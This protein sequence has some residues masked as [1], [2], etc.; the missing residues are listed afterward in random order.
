MISTAL[1]IARNT[2]ME[3][4]RQPVVL[5]LILIN[6]VLNVL[7]TWSTGFS[8]GYRSELGEV[9]GDAKLLLDVTMGSV[10]LCS[11]LLAAFVATSAVSREIENK[12]VLTVVSKPVGR[13]SV[14]LGKYLGIAGTLLI[15]LIPMLL[16]LL[17]AIRHD[18][19]STASDSVD[20]PVVVYM[21][22]AVGFS[23]VLGTATNYLYGWSF[24]QVSVVSMVPLTVLAYILILLTS[25]EWRLQSLS[26]DIKPQIMIALGSLTMAILVLGAIATAASTRL[27]QVM[28]IVVC[29]GVFVLGLLSNHLF[30]SRAF[31][32][33]P[34]AQV[35]A[36]DA[37][38]DGEAVFD[39]PGIEYLVTFKAPPTA[40]LVPGTKVYFAASPNGVGM[41][42][43]T[44]PPLPTDSS[45]ADEGGENEIVRAARPFDPSDLRGSHPGAVVITGSDDLTYTIEVVGRGDLTPSRPP[46]ADDFF[47]VET[48]RVSPLPLAAWSLIPNMQ[49]FWLLDAI[50]QANAIPLS[51][52]WLVLLYGMLQITA[53]LSLAVL[54][55]EGRDVG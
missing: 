27:G 10:F 49:N 50:T 41:A 47:F 1:T 36:A 43:P 22:S 46:Q 48:T 11:M 52:L 20:A 5:L 44:S 31:L 3:A 34:I 14:I 12:T 29:A 35:G 21:L 17:A 33:E 38:N 16:F 26:T 32:N 39:A 4:L 40:E 23:L 30:A 55:F 51:H 25:P 42:V 9:G 15:G 54:L 2:L 45:L 28:T 37:P 7:T 24:P 6:G 13:P 18:V 19:M 8:M 53:M